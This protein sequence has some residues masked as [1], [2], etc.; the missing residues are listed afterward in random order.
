ML[1][2][3]FISPSGKSGPLTFHIYTQYRDAFKTGKLTC[4]SHFRGGDGGCGL[5]LKECA[6]QSKS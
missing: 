3:R 1:Q 6:L 2:H 4:P 5:G